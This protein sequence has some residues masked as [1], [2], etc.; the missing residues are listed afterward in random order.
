MNAEFNWWLLVVGVVAGAGLAWLVLGDWNRSEADL[1]ARER[2]VE[3]VWIADAL[4][5]HNATTDPLLVEGILKLHRDYLT[6]ASPADDW[7]IEADGMADLDDDWDASDQAVVD[8]ADSS[9]VAGGHRSI[10]DGGASIRAT[11]SE[12]VS[13]APRTVAVAATPR[14]ADLPAAIA[15][16]GAG[17]DD[18]DDPQLE[19]DLDPPANPA[20]SAAAYDPES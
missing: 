14:D 2:E 13:S 12:A 7:M 3:A 20:G 10:R 1:D 11:D 18:P 19:L 15:D 9:W 16:N 4:R 6:L 17:H 5:E 8:A